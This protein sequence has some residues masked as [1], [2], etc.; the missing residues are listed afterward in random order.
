MWNF[1]EKM[2]RAH[3]C[4]RQN[5]APIFFSGVSWKPMSYIVISQ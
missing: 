3:R 1:S 2:M 4:I 5:S